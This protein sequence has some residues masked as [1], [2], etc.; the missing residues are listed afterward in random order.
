M[1]PIPRSLSA[2]TL[3]LSC[4]S[5][6]QAAAA[7]WPQWRG[8]LR[9]GALP[10]S[11]P[12]ATSWESDGPR[13]LWESES[14][15]S[16]DDGGHGSAVVSGGRVFLSVVWHRDEPSE[17]RTITELLL[18]TKLG[19]QNPASLGKELV[20]KIEAIRENLSP[21]LRGAKL[22]AFIETFVAENLSRKQK[23]LFSGFVGGRFKKGKLA[24]PLPD[25][26][27]LKERQ[28]KPF[29]SQTDFEA[30]VDGQ[31]FQEH[32][33]KAVLDAVPASK[34]VAED[35]I[36]CL[37][38]KT[39]K[40]LWITKAPGEPKGRNCS[41]T[42]CVAN[43]RVFAIG[44]THLYAVNADSGKLEWSQPLPAKA[45]GSSPLVMDGTVIILAGKLAAFEAETGKPLWEQPK[46]AGSNS[47]P[48]LWK[49]N[50]NQ[51]VLANGRSE[52]ACIHPK[53]GD[54][55]WSVEGGG[56]STPAVSGDYAAVLSSKDAIGFSG[57]KLSEKGAEK[58]WNHPTDARRSQS[59]PILHN[60]Y[61]YLFED[62]DYR[63]VQLQT[64]KILWTQK[65]S[66]SITS[67][68]LADGKIFVLANNG[69]NLLMVN[70]SPN[71]YS[72]IAK[73]NVRSLWVPSPT[74][75]NGNLFLRH[76]GG[77]RCYDL[78]AA[79]IVTTQ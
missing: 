67:P 4:T 60:G 74:I 9:N 5:A 16:D 50:G 21:S 66:S 59:S 62:G 56:D 27:K 12:L 69:N 53:T 11:P 13:K 73:A 20:D 19:Y 35:T 30:W 34:R 37:D 7:D 1:H 55:L 23:E 26:E 45:P 33:K 47:S 65:V 44:S 75:A 71:G 57:F 76:R 51:Y 49:T 17:T 79:P 15:P 8:P 46:I 36:V 64:G 77:L 29:A 14:I 3:L 42:P 41:S 40:T 61:A 43:G 54:I 31:G 28:E 25:Y 18:R 2:F 70:A 10:D 38:E 39:G 72:E 52:F 6:I 68:V 48:S 63:C 32:V 22:D 78:K 24:I 58:L